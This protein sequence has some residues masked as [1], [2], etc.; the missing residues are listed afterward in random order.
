MRVGHC[1]AF[2]KNP[3]L[4]KRLGVFLWVEFGFV[5]SCGELIGGVVRLAVN[6]WGLS[7]V[8]PIGQS[9]WLCQARL[10]FESNDQYGWVSA[11]H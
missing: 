11:S 3:R 6:S 4:R 9:V 10:L 8:K 1:Q 7:L 5:V 2:N